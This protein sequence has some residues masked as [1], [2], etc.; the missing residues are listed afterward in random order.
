MLVSGVLPILAVSL[1]HRGA[2]TL[3][4]AKLVA[5]L[6]REREFSVLSPLTLLLSNNHLVLGSSAL[7]RGGFGDAGLVPAVLSVLTSTDEELLVCS[8]RAVSRMS[9]DSHE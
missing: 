2:P 9:L 7:L 1:R 5:E 8:A 4:T 3:L 6:A